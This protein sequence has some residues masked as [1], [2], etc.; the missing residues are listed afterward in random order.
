VGVA[1]QDRLGAMGRDHP[2]EGGRVGEAA[3]G[4]RAFRQRGMVEE[5]D[6]AEI[7]RARLGEQR[8][9][10]V[11][12]R[13]PEPARR[14][15]R[16]GRLPG[17]QADDRDVAANAQIGE[18]RIAG[19]AGRPPGERRAEQRH[20]RPHIGVVISRHEAHVERVA[21]RLHPGRSA[22]ELG[23]HADVDEVARDRDVIG[24]LGPQVHDQAL[25]HRHVVEPFAPALPVD[26]A[27][28]ALEPEVRA[29]G[30]RRGR[31]MRV[32]D[33]RDRE[34]HGPPGQGTCVGGPPPLTAPQ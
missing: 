24:A 6:T 30:R 5:D 23:R 2:L 28:E 7:S 11:E 18:R 9:E 10:G 25:E 16:P 14:H 32:G 8:G 20:R 3:Q 4:R 27:H 17:G 13:A 33:V 22:A 15:Q 26:V 31:Q 19:V 21:E 34:A 29:E 12:L 1:V